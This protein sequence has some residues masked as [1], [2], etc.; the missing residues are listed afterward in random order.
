MGSTGSGRFGNYHIGEV[1]GN[2][3]IG[4]SSAGEITCPETIENIR[5]EDVATSEFFTKH[6]TLPVSHSNVE[7]RNSLFCGRLVV[8]TTDTHE[9]IGN[10]PTKYNYLITC[11]KR[12]SNYNG[13][14]ISSGISPIP[15]VVVTLNV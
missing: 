6:G 8:E 10:L 2:N 1:S 5:L 14:V 11:I 15:F 4:G 7:L 3:G 13:V 12:G 9:I